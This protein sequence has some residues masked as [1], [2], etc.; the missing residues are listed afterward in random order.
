MTYRTVSKTRQT[1]AVMTN[2]APPQA[3]LQHQEEAENLCL[4]EIIENG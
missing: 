1:L 2:K 3:E 4:A